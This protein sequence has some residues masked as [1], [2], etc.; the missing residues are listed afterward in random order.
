MY[1]YEVSLDHII[2]GLE[3]VVL[4]VV[5]L[6]QHVRRP[7]I[8]L[9]GELECLDL[10]HLHVPQQHA[11]VRHE[12]V[13]FLDLLAH[14][15]VAQG[16]DTFLSECLID[17]VHHLPTRHICNDERVHHI[18]VLLTTPELV[19]DFV[20]GRQELLADHGQLGVRR[21]GGECLRCHPK[22][23]HQLTV[24]G[25]RLHVVRELFDPRLAGRV[26]VPDLHRDLVI[27]SPIEAPLVL[28]CLAVDRQ[29]PLARQLRA[30]DPARRR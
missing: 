14:L 23:V 11:D 3:V 2:D 26:A 20:D 21:R 9:D 30:G 17:A 7:H 16:N 15:F 28:Q 8:V 13:G 12:L 18:R 19:R 27:R 29:H 1:F 4:G 6:R 25:P 22:V 24:A 5:L 10:V